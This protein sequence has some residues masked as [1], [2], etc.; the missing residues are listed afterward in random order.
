MKS[1]ELFLALGLAASVGLTGVNAN[2]SE[3]AIDE[4]V[5]A[6]SYLLAEGGE[7]GE[8]AEG[9]ESHE[10]HQGGEGGEGGEGS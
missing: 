7:G 3:I 10:E 1:V 4:P 8:G 9:D 5:D 2:E 6:N